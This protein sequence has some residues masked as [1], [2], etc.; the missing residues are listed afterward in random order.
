MVNAMKRNTLKLK[1]A[2]QTLAKAENTSVA[3]YVA[4]HAA[5]VASGQY[6]QIDAHKKDILAFASLFEVDQKDRDFVLAQFQLSGLK[7]KGDQNIALALLILDCLAT[8]AQFE[9]PIQWVLEK[10]ADIQG[11]GPHGHVPHDD[12]QEMM[13]S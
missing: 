2:L 1:K 4:M 12:H 3:G 9:I 10:R 13:G 11:T 6:K 5:E 8:N 7:R